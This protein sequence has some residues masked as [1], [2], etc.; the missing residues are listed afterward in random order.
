MT[1]EQLKKRI[2]ELHSLENELNTEN[3]KCDKQIGVILNQKK[4]LAKRISH[5][6]KYR[7]RLIN[8][9]CAPKK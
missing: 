2:A 3:G 6:M 5:N 8:E 9:M 1:T 4:K 7:N